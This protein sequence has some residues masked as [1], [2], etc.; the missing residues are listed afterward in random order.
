MIWAL[1]PVKPLLLGKS[2]LAGAVPPAARSAMNRLLLEHTL[3]V[4]RETRG[5]AETMVISRDPEAL[6]IAREFEARTLLEH[7][8]SLLNTALERATSVVSAYKLPGLLVLPADLPLLSVG[9]LEVMLDSAGAPPAVVVAPDRHETGTN[10]LLIMPPGKISFSFGP[11]SFAVHCRSAKAAGAQLAIVRRVGLA[12]DLD[13]PEDLAL[14]REMQGAQ[15]GHLV[16]TIT[17]PL[18]ATSGREETL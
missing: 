4:I 16:Q 6:A 1:V 15:S 14:L 8:G 5:I 3:S 17:R 13:L 7:G 18:E 10:A 2:R 12:L 9:D 11:D